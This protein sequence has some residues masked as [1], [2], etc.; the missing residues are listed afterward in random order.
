[1]SFL[2]IMTSILLG[3]R[4]WTMMRTW[5][6]WRQI[7]PRPA[8]RMERWRKVGWFDWEA[9]VTSFFV[10]VEVLEVS[11]VSP[12][13]SKLSNQGTVPL[14]LSLTHSLTL[15]LLFFPLQSQL[16]TYPVRGVGRRERQRRVRRKMKRRKRG[17][18]GRR[19]MRRRRRRV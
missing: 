17:K 1:M 10:D 2:E 11:S 4:N 13:P 3:M 9:L 15:I 14:S 5:M 12:P 18:K 8:A 16:K 6:K 7:F 19:R